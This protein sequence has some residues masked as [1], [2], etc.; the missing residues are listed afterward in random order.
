MKDIAF[1]CRTVLLAG[2]L[3]ASCPP[4]PALATEEPEVQRTDIFVAGTEGYH[5]FRIPSLLVTKKGTL[6]AFCEGRKDNRSDR[7]N[8][9]LVYR[10]S[11]DGG[12]TWSPLKVLWDDGKN[13]C[14]NPCP[15]V[16][17]DTGTIWLLLTHN[18]GEDGESAI[19]GKSAKSTRTVWVSRSD[20]DGKNWS[21][22]TEITSTT[23]VAAWGW[24]ATGPGI[25]IQ[26]RHG[27][28]RGRLVVP[29]D[30]SYDDPGGNIRGPHN[31]GSHTVY[32]DDHGTTWKLGG[33]IRPSSNEC[34]IVEMADGTGTLLMNMRAYFGRN[35]RTHATSRDGGLTW[36]APKDNGYLIEPVCQASILRYD[37][38]DPQ[39]RSLLLF[40]NPAS[41]QRVR[42][43]L[44][45]SFD[46]GR[47]WPVKR[48]LHGGPAAYSCLGVLPNKTP[49]KTIVCLFEAG[50]KSAYEKIV[51]ARLPLEW[52]WKESGN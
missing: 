37:W 52:L 46:E 39:T 27:P 40:S 18:L 7:G 24:Y 29:C 14:G 35:R 32:S 9:D 41:K 17:R 49:S 13:T 6:L 25:G 47:T 4:R 28:H 16:D 34:Q 23:K 22:P 20:D 8:I 44:K 31:Y 11:E 36:T 48:T 5:S 33:V 21:A 26:I 45:L 42:M 51:L 10:R 50:E 15:V 30:H 2:L 3:L 12:K 43:T 19:I 1:D 38:P